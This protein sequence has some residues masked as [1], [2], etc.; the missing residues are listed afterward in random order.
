M[1][2]LPGS[3]PLHLRPELAQVLVRSFEDL[4]RPH[5]AEGLHKYRLQGTEPYLTYIRS[6]ASVAIHLP[7]L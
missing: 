3:G 2:T 1:V 7:L 6:R 4:E 5:V